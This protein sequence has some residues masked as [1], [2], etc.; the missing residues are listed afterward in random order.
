MPTLKSGSQMHA[1]AAELVQS[2]TLVSLLVLDVDHFASINLEHGFKIGDKAIALLESLLAAETEYAYRTGSDQFAVLQV[3]VERGAELQS[4]FRLACSRQLGFSVT[5]SGGGVHVDSSLFTSTESTRAMNKAA[6]EALALAKHHGRSNIIW[7]T[8][9]DS[10]VDTAATAVG[11]RLFMD[12]TRISASRA[13]QMELESRID[14]PTGLYNRRG[15]DDIFGRLAEG[16]YR[17]KKPMA[18][19]FM[20]SDS[21]KKIN[22]TGGHEAGERFIVDLSTVLRSIVRHSDF[23]FRWG[24]DEFA[25]VLEPTEAASASTLAE[26]IRV[27]VAERTSGTVSVGVYYGIPREPAEAVRTADEAMYAAKRDG[28]DRVMTVQGQMEG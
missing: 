21:L 7:V 15:F 26:R 20:D 25:V 11:R 6:S 5:L 24:G 4:A 18:L 27:A 10:E 22:D 2:G 9:A 12:L 8:D 23:I 16:S 3:I 14:A 19:I 13:Q 17:S 28:G 1:D